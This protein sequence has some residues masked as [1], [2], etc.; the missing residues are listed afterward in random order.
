M[1]R[2]KERLAR[3]EKQDE[4]LGELQRRVDRLEKADSADLDAVGD[5]RLS[6]SVA[7]IEQRLVSLEDTGVRGSGL[8]AKAQKVILAI[9]QLRE[10]LGGAS[11]FAKEFAGLKTVAAKDAD[12]IKV[13]A[14]LESFADKGIPTLALLRRRFDAMGGKIFSSSLALEGDGWLERAANKLASL[15]TLRRTS[16]GN[17]AGDM[18]DAVVARVEASLAAG[19]LKE[20]VAA[21]EGLRG[22]AAAAAAPWLADARARL[23]AERV[24]A[25]LHV[26][27]VSLL[28]PRQE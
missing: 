6:T 25:M 18:A 17:A 8:T 27:A 5:K 11:P 22:P 23:T 26:F 4:S 12:I 1:Q 10:A 14:V 21:L 3:L 15:V 9:G 28:G 20:S 24:K 2:L 13:I 7:K 19:D 16:G